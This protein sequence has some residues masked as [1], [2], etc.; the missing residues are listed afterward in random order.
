MRFCLINIMTKMFTFI[1]DQENAFDP[2]RL[3]DNVERAV[4]IGKEH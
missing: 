1:Y 3:P 2:L 4:R